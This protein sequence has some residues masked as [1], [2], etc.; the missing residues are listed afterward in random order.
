MKVARKYYGQG[1]A[2]PEAILL[3]SMKRPRGAL[4]GNELDAPPV[5]HVA[6]N[7]QDVKDPRPCVSAAAAS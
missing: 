4:L 6:A 1:H 2:V 7:I 3:P 5:V